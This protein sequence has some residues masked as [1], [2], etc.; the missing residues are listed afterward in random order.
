MFSS[1]PVSTSADGAGIVGSKNTGNRPSLNL[2]LYLPAVW[3]PQSLRS[4]KHK[5]IG[6]VPDITTTARHRQDAIMK[7]S[8]DTSKHCNYSVFNHKLLGYSK[9]E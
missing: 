8:V 5:D 2:N 7:K 6:C 1:A 9:E 4:D 3:L